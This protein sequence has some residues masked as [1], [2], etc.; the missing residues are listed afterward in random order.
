MIKPPAR[1][2]SADPRRRALLLCGVL[3]YVAY[4]A[5]EIIAG[6]MVRGLGILFATPALFALW[7]KSPGLIRLFSNRLGPRMGPVAAAAALLCLAVAIIYFFI[8]PR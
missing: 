6:D 1:Y 2:Q 3:L 8:L 4:L 5:F 7:A